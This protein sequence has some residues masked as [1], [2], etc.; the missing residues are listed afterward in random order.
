MSTRLQ[1]PSAD[2]TRIKILKT[3]LNLFMQYGFAGTSMGKIAEKAEINQ[4]LIYHHF[5][6]KKKLWQQVKMT[7]LEGVNTSPINP[8]PESVRQFLMEAIEQRTTIYTQCPQLKILIGWQKLELSY[9]K[10]HLIGIPN[11]LISPLQWKESIQSLHKRKLLNP[12]FPVEM[13]LVWLLASIDGLIND[14]L[15]LFENNPEKQQYYVKM[16]V[17]NFEKLFASRIE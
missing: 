8:E 13:I 16:L 11:S 3:A 6:N 9:N 17:D 15:A 7:I 12:E 10:H 4:T 5:G 14:D 1:R 2:V